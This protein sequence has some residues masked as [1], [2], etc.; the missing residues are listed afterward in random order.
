MDQLLNM[1]AVQGL[2]AGITLRA[3]QA[4]FADIRAAV[5]SLIESP[6]Y[7]QAAERARQVVLQHDA[8]QRFPEIIAEILQR[9][10]CS[11]SVASTERSGAN[12]A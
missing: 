8:K 2:G 11:V 10:S 9:S 7:L 12:C 4:K 3:G 5:K 1:N 6:T